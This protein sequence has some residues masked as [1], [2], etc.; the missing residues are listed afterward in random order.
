MIVVIIFLILHLNSPAAVVGSKLLQ[1]IDNFEREMRKV[2]N[3]TFVITKPTSILQ[4]RVTGKYLLPRPQIRLLYPRGFGL[5]IPGK[6]IFNIV[7]FNGIIGYV[8]I[9]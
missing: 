2:D 1:F 8:I 6:F 7:L 9:I 4:H 3:Q 5:S